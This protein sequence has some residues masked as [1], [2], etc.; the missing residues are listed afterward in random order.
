MK[1]LIMQLSPTSYNSSLYGL[2][3]FIIIL[4]SNTVSLCMFSRNIRDQ[5][6]HPYK[7]KVKLVLYILIF[8]VFVQQTRRQKVLKG[9]VASITRI[10]SALNFFRNQ[11]LICYCRSQICELC[12]I[13]FKSIIYHGRRVRLTTSPTFVRRLTR[14]CGSFDASQPYGPPRPVTAIALP[15]FPI[16]TL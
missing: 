9:M 15:L 10:K 1:L 11:I 12:H 4:F 8:Y 6:L 16:F 2:Y 14:K 3:I 5:I 13:F 7:I